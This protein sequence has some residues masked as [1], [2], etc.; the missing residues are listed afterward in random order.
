MLYRESIARS[1]WF[2][3][4]E[5]IVWAGFVFFV[6]SG[7]GLFPHSRSE[8]RLLQPRLYDLSSDVGQRRLC[9]LR[10][11]WL[12]DTIRPVRETALCEDE[13]QHRRDDREEEGCPQAV[14][15]ELRCGQEMMNKVTCTI[16]RI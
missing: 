9:R 7:D 5:R 14:A 1:G 3:R 10:H 6:A 11:L 2:L 8:A 13:E 12:H 4:Q 15:C 16:A